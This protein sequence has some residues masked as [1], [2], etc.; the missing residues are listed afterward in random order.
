MMNLNKAAR[1]WIKYAAIW[2]PQ[3]YLGATIMA[4]SLK[5]KLWPKLCKRKILARQLTGLYCY[6]N[7]YS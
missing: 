6:G 2:E 5:E 4:E 1:A 7:L 3:K